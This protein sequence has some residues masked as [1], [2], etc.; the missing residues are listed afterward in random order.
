LVYILGIHIQEL[1]II[2]GLNPISNAV[3]HLPKSVICKVVFNPNSCVVK[4]YNIV[5]YLAQ[6]PCAMSTLE[7]IQH[8]PNQRRTLLST[9]GAMDPE[10]S[11]LITFN[12]DY[13][14]ERVSCHLAFQIQ[15]FVSEH[16]IHR[17][18]LDEVAS[19][20][21]MYFPSWRSLGYPTLILSPRTLKAF[22]R[23][24]FQ[25]HGLLKYFIVTLKGNTFPV[26]I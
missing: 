14:K 10:E 8:C 7:V 6:A 9:I 13:F 22:D 2:L 18:V 15:V 11:N 19:T 16:T 5:E 3:L 4:N 24:G 1:Q 20:C 23:H 26:D 17:I 12:M 21:L 25:P